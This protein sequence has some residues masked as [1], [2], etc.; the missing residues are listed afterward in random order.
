[1]KATQI[2]R[3]SNGQSFSQKLKLTTIQL[4][5]VFPNIQGEIDAAFPAEL[6]VCQG[7]LTNIVLKIYL[8]ITSRLDS[9][10]CIWHRSKV[11]LQNFGKN[12]RRPKPEP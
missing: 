12:V 11:D 10:Y 1:M 8:L 5:K 2:L 7:P 4:A 3:N 6:P 9:Y